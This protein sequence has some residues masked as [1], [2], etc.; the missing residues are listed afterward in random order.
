M[1]LRNGTIVLVADGSK[2]LLLRNN[3]DA[4]FPELQVIA[5]CEIV[6]PTSHEQMSDAPG[7]TFSSHTRRSAYPAKDP[8]QEAEDRFAA[9]VAGKLGK[10][11][12]EEKGEVVVVAP[13]HM[14]SVL[15]HHYEPAVKARLVA[16]IDKDLTKHPV[17]EI[18]RLIGHYQA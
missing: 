8:H 17:S 15:R 11:V 3:G 18:T 6:N 1:K 4:T 7:V 12:A 2:M 14:L 10:H 5:H 9:E 16:E 13:P